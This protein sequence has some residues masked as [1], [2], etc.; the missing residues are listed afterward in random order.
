MQIAEL[1]HQLEVAQHQIEVR[2]ELITERG[3]VLVGADGQTEGSTPTNGGDTR[4]L[5][6][7][8]TSTPTSSVGSADAPDRKTSAGL[9]HSSSYSC[10]P[11]QR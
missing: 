5:A 6:N 11:S 10:P 8:G 9:N 2:D 1:N 3:L 4:L 7:G